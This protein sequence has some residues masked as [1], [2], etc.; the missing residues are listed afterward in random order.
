MSVDE[1]LALS[2]AG[3]SAKEEKSRKGIQ[4]VLGYRVFKGNEQWRVRWE[5]EGEEQDT[6][7]VWGV[8]DTS[9]LRAHAE[10]LRESH[11]QL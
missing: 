3:A 9:E 11:G 4:G 6:W 5:G 1:L 10:R 7:E 8:L 2:E